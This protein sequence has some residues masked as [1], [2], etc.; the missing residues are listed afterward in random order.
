MSEKAIEPVAQA[1][2]TNATTVE[3]DVIHREIELRHSDGALD[4]IRALL[5]FSDNNSLRFGAAIYKCAICSQLLVSSTMLLGS[6]C[7]NLPILTQQWR[8][9][10]DRLRQYLRWFG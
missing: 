4:V 1:R 9:R 5:V 8:P 10:V 7:C 6:C 3:D 2:D